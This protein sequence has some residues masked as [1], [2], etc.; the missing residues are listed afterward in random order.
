MRKPVRKSCRK[1]KRNPPL[2]S[3]DIPVTQAMLVKV[4]DELK[5]DISSV[6]SEV[7][8]LE[9]KMDAR[10]SRVDSRFSQMDAKF[11]K[12]ISEVHRIGLLVEEQNARNKYVLDGYGLLNDRIDKNEKDIAELKLA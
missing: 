7:K 12:V 5:S 1:P 10:F 6:R 3:P 9:Q 8:A 11:D 4:R 2:K